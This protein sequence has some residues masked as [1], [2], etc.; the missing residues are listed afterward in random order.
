MSEPQP[1]NT[2]TAP[3]ELAP[4]LISIGP[5]TAL[6][7][8]RS[9]C[10]SCGAPLGLHVGADGACVVCTPV[11]HLDRP[12]IDAEARLAWIPEMT[13]AAL[14]CLVRTLHCQ[15][16]AA[17]ENGAGPGHAA[18]HFAQQALDARIALATRY[19]GTDRPSELAQALRLLPPEV[20]A[21]RHR[22]L[23]GLR[24]LPRG[25]FFVGNEDVY[26]AVLASWSGAAT[27]ETEHA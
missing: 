13:Q 6:P 22:P 4:L 25:Q 19:L 11:L 10:A 26:P 21:Q 24:V 16:W 8:S 18:L 1:P 5:G 17:G 3:T 20:Y 23:A 27:R 9:T 12:R 7:S 2:G 15:L 14:C